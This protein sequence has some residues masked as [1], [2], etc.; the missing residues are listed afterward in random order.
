PRVRGIRLARALEGLRPHPQLRLRR[1][2]RSAVVPA[3]PL[4]IRR[5]R[6]RAPPW[7][8]PSLVRRTDL[9]D[10]LAPP[11][12]P[13]CFEEDEA[14]KA[15]GARVG[16]A[17]EATRCLERMHGAERRHPLFDPPLVP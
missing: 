11:A 4:R 15:L 16:L 10:R 12:R 13:N 9:E 6:R 5:M 7:L 2:V 3:A 14:E 1:L 8:K 17:L